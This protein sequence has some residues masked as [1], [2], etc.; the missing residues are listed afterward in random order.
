MPWSHNISCFPD[1]PAARMMTT[2]AILVRKARFLMAVHTDDP[3]GRE[4]LLRYLLRPPLAQERLE[5]RPDGL[6]R[7]TLMWYGVPW[8]KRSP[9]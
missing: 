8:S 4:A 9:G 3:V 6:V 5:Q 2:V 1:A 7:I